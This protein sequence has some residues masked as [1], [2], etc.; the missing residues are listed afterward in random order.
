MKI[1]GIGLMIC[2]AISSEAV[3]A[4]SKQSSNGYTVTSKTT[5]DFNETLIDGKFKAPAGFFLQ[6]RKS[7]SLSQMVKL[8]SHFRRELMSSSAGAKSRVK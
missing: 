4:K 8:R 7:Q 1:I 6:G 2:F 5:I 3:F